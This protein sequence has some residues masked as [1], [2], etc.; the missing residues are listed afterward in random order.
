MAREKIARC[1]DE[2]FLSPHSLVSPNARPSGKPHEPLGPFRFLIVALLVRTRGA[3]VR[4]CCHDRAW[5]QYA[6][7]GRASL[8]EA[9]KR[10]DKSCEELAIRLE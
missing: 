6:G 10:P 3:Q 4:A 1:Q 9:P 8:P 5:K 7:R 2:V